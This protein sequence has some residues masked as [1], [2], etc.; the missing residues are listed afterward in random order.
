MAL[1][2]AVILAQCLRDR[3]DT[4]SAFAA[5]VA[6]R[7]SRVE[8]VVEYGR[9]GSAQKAAAPI[10]RAIRDALLPIAFRRAAKDDGRSMAWLQAHH[11]E[12][13]T[14]IAAMTGGGGPSTL[15]PS[16]GRP[17]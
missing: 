11:L 2:D 4:R 12:F 15:A 8:R 7:R 16:T 5:F 10:T 3:P 17:N 14:A 13:E 9:R 6:L 1:E